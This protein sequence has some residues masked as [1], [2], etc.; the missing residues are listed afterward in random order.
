MDIAKAKEF[1]YR[2][3]FSDNRHLYI[4]KTLQPLLDISGG[5]ITDIF[6]VLSTDLGDK[7]FYLDFN[8][9]GDPIVMNIFLHKKYFLEYYKDS[10]KIVYL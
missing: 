5:K 8:Y 4:S 9:C 6:A 7:L 2:P 1:I 10:R 3:I